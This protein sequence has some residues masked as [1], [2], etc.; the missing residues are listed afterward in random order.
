MLYQTL[1]VFAYQI[2]F[3]ILNSYVT[4]PLA[5]DQPLKHSLALGMII[6][7]TGAIVMGYRT[8]MYSLGIIAIVLFRC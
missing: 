7:I 3:G 4:T 6:S 5:P 8:R 1:F 2:R